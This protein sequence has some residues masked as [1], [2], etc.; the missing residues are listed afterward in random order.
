M[1]DG[2]QTVSTQPTDVVRRR[3]TPTRGFTLWL[4]SG[5]LRYGSTAVV[6]DEEAQR[7][8]EGGWATIID[9]DAA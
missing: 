4:K 7:F 9:E 5:E 1:S 8:V 6:E 2:E 3:I